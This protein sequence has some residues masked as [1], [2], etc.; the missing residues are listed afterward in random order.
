MSIYNI[1]IKLKQYS[2]KAIIGNK[3]II[4][5]V[6]GMFREVA[7]KYEVIYRTL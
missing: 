2:L 5:D 4:I 7:E 3:P 1:F 6:R